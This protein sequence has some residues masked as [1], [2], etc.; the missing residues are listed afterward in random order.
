MALA[1][2]KIANDY[3]GDGKSGISFLGAQ[4]SP[5]TALSKFTATS[6]K[7]VNPRG[8]ILC[9]CRVSLNY[10]REYWGA[11]E[12]IL[13][14]GVLQSGVT[15]RNSFCGWLVVKLTKR[16]VNRSAS[17]DKLAKSIDG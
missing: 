1:N 10:F 16:K 5:G 9:L 12:I 6:T 14:T 4:L 7:L 3:V 8:E 15:G 2:D 11:S 17:G 13:Q